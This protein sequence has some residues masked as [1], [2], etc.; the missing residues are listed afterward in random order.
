MSKVQMLRALVKQR[1]TAA[2]DEIFGLFERTIAEYEEELCR[3]KEENDR[4]RHLLDAVFNLEGR[5]P[6]ADVQ[7]VLVGKED[8]RSSLAQEDP[9]PPLIKEEQEERWSSQD[10]EPL[11]DLDESD[12][13]K[14]T[15]THVPVKSEDDEEQPQSSQAKETEPRASSSAQYMKIK[16]FQNDFGGPDAD[17]NS[18]H[19]NYLQPLAEEMASDSSELDSE[20]S[21]RWKGICEPQPTFKSLVHLSQSRCKK[22]DKPFCCAECGK[23]FEYKSYLK[24]HMRTHT[25]EKPFSCSVCGKLFTHVSTLTKHMRCHT[26]ERPYS[27]SVCNKCFRQSG[28]VVAHMRIHTGERPYVCSVCNKSFKKKTALTY[29]MTV[30]TGAKQFTCSI[31]GKS[32]SRKSILKKH[33][34]VDVADADVTTDVTADVTL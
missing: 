31:C 29:H 34:C 33:K 1:L 17:A 5:L 27:C 23:T 6:G 21:D 10:G 13:I 28:Q 26:G 22:R 8:Q 32:Y 25:G 3:S 11:Q 24:S 2:V 19:D 30:H 14:F 20:H 4:Q 7:Q 9:D 15:L 16:A 12:V 18:D